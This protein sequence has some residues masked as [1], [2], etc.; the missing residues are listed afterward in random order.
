MDKNRIKLEI[1]LAK[2]LLTNNIKKLQLG[3]GENT[4]EGFFNTD[5]IVADGVYYVDECQPLPFRDE[6]FHYI[7][8]EHNFEHLSYH[9]GRNLLRECYR[10]LKPGGVLRLTMPCLEFLLQIYQKP[11]EPLFQEYM[12]WHFQRYAPEMYSDF[13]DNLP[14]S[15]LISNFMRMWGHQCIY[16]R[17]TIERSLILAGYQKVCFCEVGQSEHSEL[18]NLERHQNL[19]TKQFN[20]LESICLEATK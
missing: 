19:Y 14:P 4:I 13:K 10:V 17:P 8:L 3:C 6:T 11:E 16:D 12:K 2:Y 18:Q 15:L 9:D 1:A 7:F 5:I 20:I